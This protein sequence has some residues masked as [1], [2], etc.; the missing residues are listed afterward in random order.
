M[1][2]IAFL[3]IC[4][5]KSSLYSCAENEAFDTKM[6]LYGLSFPLPQVLPVTNQIITFQIQ[7]HETNVRTL[8]IVQAKL[9]EFKQ[10]SQFDAI[11]KYITLVSSMNYSTII[12]K[13]WAFKITINQ[14]TMMQQSIMA[15]IINK[16]ITVT[17]KSA[18]AIQQIPT[19]FET[20]TVCART[21]RRKYGI[22]G[23]RKKVCNDHSVPRGL[24]MD[25]I[26]FVKNRLIRKLDEVQI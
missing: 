11:T 6:R 22:A 3:L 18:T 8:D 16:N 23:P 4:C 24:T 26:L 5:A 2:I 13:E 12:Q 1:N 14:G 25:E 7:D 21:G 10:I 15:K 19:F 17:I 20:K 9:S